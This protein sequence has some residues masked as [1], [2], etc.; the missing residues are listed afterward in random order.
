MFIIQY[1]RDNEKT[2]T[3]Y[4]KTESGMRSKVKELSDDP[5]VLSVRIFKEV[6]YGWQQSL[7]DAN[8]SPF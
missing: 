8:Q 5:L 4:Y 6:T 3:L 1:R 7:F 2:K